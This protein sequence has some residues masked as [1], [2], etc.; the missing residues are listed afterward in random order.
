MRTQAGLRAAFIRL[1]TVFDGK[2]ERDKHLAS[3][4]LREMDTVLVNSWSHL[5]DM[6]I[7]KTEMDKIKRI[8]KRRL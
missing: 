7:T 1:M 5:S 3:V 2:V 4:I 8:V 6:G